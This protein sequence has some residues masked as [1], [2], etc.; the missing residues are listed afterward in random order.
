MLMR[1]YNR[2]IIGYLATRPPI[3]TWFNEARVISC[4]FAKRGILPRKDKKTKSDRRDRRESSLT[5][6][7]LE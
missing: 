3:I 1:K 5:P 6:I 4:D 7:E 2:F